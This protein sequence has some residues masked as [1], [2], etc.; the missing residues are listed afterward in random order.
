MKNG[1]Y[2]IKG[3][4]PLVEKIIRN[5]GHENYYEDGRVF[6]VDEEYAL[7]SCGKSSTKPFC[8][9]SH[10]SVH[11]RGTESASRKKYLDQAVEY[12]GPGLI[13]TDQEN[14]CAYARFC[15]KKHGDVWNLTMES[16]DET[17]KQEAI[18]AAKMCPSGRLIAWDKETK[19]PILPDDDPEITIIQ[20]PEKKCSGPIW[21]KGNVPLISSDGTEYERRYQMTL[22][23]CGESDNKPFCDAT[24]VSIRFDDDYEKQK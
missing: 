10:A 3:G 1:P 8:D 12:D 7:C 19:Q 9:G 14:L 22:C 20:D 21:V 15:H 17:Y 13:L 4:I 11:H 23:R 2:L 5:D 18:D 16:D 24:H 6:T